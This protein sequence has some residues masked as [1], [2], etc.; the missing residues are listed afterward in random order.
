MNGYLASRLGHGSVAAHGSALRL[1]NQ[2]GANQAD[3]LAYADAF[4]FM[5]FIGLVALCLIPLMIPVPGPS[6]ERPAK[7]PLN[8]RPDSGLRPGLAGQP[9]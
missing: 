3:T 5:A 6:S 2:L 1:L 4:L 7:P 8:P 9:S